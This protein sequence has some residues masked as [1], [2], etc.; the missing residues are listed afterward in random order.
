MCMW[1]SKRCGSEVQPSTRPRGING[2]QWTKLRWQPTFWPLPGWLP[3]VAPAARGIAQGENCSHGTPYLHLIN[4]T[5]V[6]I[7]MRSQDSSPGA[8]GKPSQPESGGYAAIACS[9]SRCHLIAS[10]EKKKHDGA[11]SQ[12][13]RQTCNLIMLTYQS[14]TDA[15]LP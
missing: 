5:P 12:A 15:P 4:N 13:I 1:D 10:N 7:V 11:V 2:N 14:D 3:L 6:T 9:V 8:A